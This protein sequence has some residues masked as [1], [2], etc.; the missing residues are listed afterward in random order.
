MPAK[1]N[2][3]DLEPLLNAEQN[4][5]SV[6]MADSAGIDNKALGI[7]AANIAVLLF[8][9]QADLSFSSW[10]THASLLVPYII[11]LV[12]NILTILPRDYKGPGVDIAASPE[13]LEMSR[14]ALVAQ[15]LANTQSAIAINNRLNATRWRYCAV[16]LVFS[17]IGTGILFVIL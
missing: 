7:S 4:H 2:A 1:P 11:S 14:D 10:F 15:L 17:A 8:I 12:F 9:A 6:A 16:S 5:L 3:V 13:Y